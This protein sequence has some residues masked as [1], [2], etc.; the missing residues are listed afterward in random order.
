VATQSNDRKLEALAVKVELPAS[1]YQRAVERFKDLG[2]WLGRTESSLHG[3]DPHVFAQGSFA[4]GTAIT[5]PDRGENYDLDLSCNLR[6][7]VTRA[8]HT[9]RQLKELLRR[10]LESYRNA[11]NIQDK[12]EEKNRCWRVHY[13]GHP[14]FH[15]DTVPGI[16][17]D[18][19]RRRELTTLMEK[20]ITMDAALAASVANESMWIT[21]RLNPAYPHIS[22]D[23]EASNPA[24]Y[25]RWFQ[26]RIDG[27]LGELTK[28]AKVSAVPFYERKST[29]QRA[30]QLLKVHRDNMF[31]KYPDSRPISI[32]ITTLAARAYRPT[33]SLSEAM[34]TILAELNRFRKSGESELLNPTNPNESF[35]DKWAHADY[36]EH[37]LQES[38]NQWVDQVTV[39]FAV[40]LNSGT[41]QTLLKEASDRFGVNPESTLLEA[42]I[43]AEA[44]T[45]QAARRP[46]R[47]EI[48]NDSPRPY[49]CS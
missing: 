19:V 1:A 47:V 2:A 20:R 49:T 4:L 6:S 11:R 13:Q 37:K 18:D 38:F 15:M 35:T 25:L 12:L 7:G 10:E 46:P 41:E 17:V 40:Y 22:L 31:L 16:P 30:I 8:S 39:D 28:D 33:S 27:S 14:G 34:Q 26:S 23:W 3:F 5:P 9:Q 32:I 24:G 44:G 48:R 21:D 45:A 42:A 43:A 36:K 29:L